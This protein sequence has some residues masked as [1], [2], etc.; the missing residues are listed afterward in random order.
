MIMLFINRKEEKRML[1]LT[2]KNAVVKDNG[3]GVEVNG[4]PL[5]DIIST[6]LG[7]KVG[8]TRSG[9]GKDLPVWDCNSCDVTVIISPNPISTEIIKDGYVFDSVKELEENAYE[10]FEKS[11]EGKG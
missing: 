8:A 9:Y 1:T 11:K 7:T 10:Q 5:T 2:F 4:T 3:Y 6:A